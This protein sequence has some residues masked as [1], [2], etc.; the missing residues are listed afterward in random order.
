[1]F[2]PLL[3]YDVFPHAKLHTRWFG[4]RL[5]RVLP[6][7]QFGNDGALRIKIHL[8][9]VVLAM[10][11]LLASCG[12]L[13]PTAEQINESLEA[14]LRAVDGPWRGVQGA[15][16]PPTPTLEF[17]LTQQTNG[18]LQ[19]SGTMR[20]PNAESSI[21]ITVTGTFHRPTLVL[22]FGGMVYE[23]RVVLAAFRGDYI[24]VGG[25]SDSCRLTAERVRTDDSYSS[26]GT[27]MRY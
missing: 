3:S 15:P 9:F 14:E 25:I 17:S 1:M 6:C 11:P 12:V 16:G 18:Q 23:G 13:G 5:W 8:R 2:Q 22:T 27:S 26:T 24:T 4:G 21:P 7:S 20:E 10:V 19:G